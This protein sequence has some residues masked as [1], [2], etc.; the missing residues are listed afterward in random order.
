MKRKRFTESQIHAVLKESEAGMKTGELCRKHGITGQ[1]FYRWKAKYGGMELS[2]IRR[3]KEL[4][5]ENSDLKRLV[6]NLAMENDGLKVVV[7]KKW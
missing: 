5:K 3:L 7:S 2:D 6:A 4:E 1:T